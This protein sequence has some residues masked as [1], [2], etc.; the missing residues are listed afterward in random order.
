MHYRLKTY[1][2]YFSN[3]SIKI[4][5]FVVV[6]LAILFIDMQIS[7]TAHLF[8][9]DI[10]GDI[11]VAIFIAISFVYLIVQQYILSYA[12]KEPLQIQVESSSFRRIKRIINFMI[13]FIVICFLTIILEILISQ[14]YD[15]IM[16][17]LVLVA[18]NAISIIAMSNMASKFFTWYQR[19]KEPTILI[20]A[21]MYCIIAITAFVT[22]LFMGTLLI[23]QPEKIEPN[24]RVVLPT[25]EQGST[26]SIINYLYYYLAILSYVITWVITSLLLKDYSNKLGKTKY[27]IILSLPLIFYLSQLLVTQFGLFIPEDAVGNFTF[28]MWFLFFY[29]PSSLI[30]GILFSIPF[31]LIIRRTKISK[32]LENFLRITAYGLI[33]FFAAG[34]ATVYHTPYPPYGLLTVAVIGPSSYLMALGVYYSARIISRN[35]TIEGQMKKSDKYSQFFARLGSAEKEKVL[36]EIVEEIGKK[37][38]P[39]DR[40]VSEELE[41]VDREIVEYLKK[42][43]ADKRSQKHLD[44]N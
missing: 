40:K 41:T 23:M 3:I 17:L 10:S 44:S 31:Y 6:I 14:Y 43:K 30:G 5:F 25:I 12:N 20:F 11:G 21:T 2:D 15:S 9:K 39:D 16:L 22:V 18:T 13:F 32:P 38:P 27:W 28:Q 42:F 8:Y 29:T 19:R 35:R 7:N 4:K 34:S 33:L 36:T 26:L 1:F 37:L 24:I